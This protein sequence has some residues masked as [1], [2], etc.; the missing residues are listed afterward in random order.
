MTFV[1]FV[2]NM[3]VRVNICAC[4]MYTYIYSEYDIFESILFFA[5]IPHEL[6]VCVYACVCVMYAHIHTEYIIF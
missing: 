4:I 6:Q 3:T 1:T 2:L 5:L